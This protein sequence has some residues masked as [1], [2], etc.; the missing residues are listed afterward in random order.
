[1][2]MPLIVVAVLAAVIGVALASQPLGI[3]LVLVGCLAAILAR[4]A[5]AKAYQTEHMDTLRIQADALQKLL[6]KVD[7]SGAL[8]GA[9]A[10]SRRMPPNQ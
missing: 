1:M 2:V 7:N 6:G 8:T 3:P 4:M 9:A 5:Q 10:A